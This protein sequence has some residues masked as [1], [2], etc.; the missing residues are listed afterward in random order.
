MN[1]IGP[2]KIAVQIAQVRR[3]IK[4][5]HV[6][7][8]TMSVAVY[9]DQLEELNATLSKLKDK[10]IKRDVLDVWCVDNPSDFECRVYG[11]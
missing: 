8:K 3:E 9:Y 2:N 11:P 1:I 6:Q 4:A 7:K 10:Q 5:L